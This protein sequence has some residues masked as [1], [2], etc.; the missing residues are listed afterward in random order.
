MRIV[1]NTEYI[2]KRKRISRIAALVGFLLLAST[3]L[4]IFQPDLILIAYAVLFTGFI[5]FNFGMQ[6]LGKWSRNPRN[7][8]ILDARLKPLPDA[9]YT[10]VHYVQVGKR[11]VEHVLVHP[12]GLLV[13]TSRELPGKVSVKDR[14][15]RKQ[16]VGFMRFFAMSGPQLG[17]PTADLE[18]DVEA[19]DAF[20]AEHGYDID[21]YGA[22]VFLNDRIEIEAEDPA[23][24]A[25][26]ADLLVPF[27]NAIEPDANFTNQAREE[28]V[29]ALADHA[30]SEVEVAKPTRRPVKVKRRAA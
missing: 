21:I 13:L 2:R 30:G 26:R 17:N 24:P 23:Y 11:V 14:R 19:L 16:G 18:S 15:W 22:V 9:K 27:V 4:L 6:Q 25:L 28:L 20:A 8:E 10:L 5:V 1:R 29:R 12:G 7:D 3:F